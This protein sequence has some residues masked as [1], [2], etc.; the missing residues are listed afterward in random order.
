MLRPVGILQFVSSGDVRMRWCPDCE[1]EFA[2]VIER[3]ERDGKMVVEFAG[4]PDCGNLGEPLPAESSEA[5]E[6]F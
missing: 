5:G 3:V 4:C 1:K 2:A 6:D